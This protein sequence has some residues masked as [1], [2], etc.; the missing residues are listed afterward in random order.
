MA[1]LRVPVEDA[2]SA[3]AHPWVRA[4]ACGRLPGAAGQS[5]CRNP[6]ERGK[7]A[8][9]PSPGGSRPVRDG[10]RAWAVGARAL[11]RGGRR[12]GGQEG[13]RVDKD[14]CKQQSGSHAPHRQEG[15][16]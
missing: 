14:R 11:G 3:P 1:N 8:V 4:L 12:Q 9:G 13:R 10:P 5:P 6:G 16:M 7:G 15:T 2:P